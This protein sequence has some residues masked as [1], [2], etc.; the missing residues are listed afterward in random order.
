MPN[1][2]FH[3]NY[4]TIVFLRVLVMNRKR[5]LEKFS[6]KKIIIF[7]NSFM[8]MAIH[9]ISTYIKHIYKTLYICNLILILSEHL[10]EVDREII[11]LFYK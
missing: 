10:E 11:S 4:K 2:D 5:S 6:V 3:L 9:Y 1:L 7:N 8:I